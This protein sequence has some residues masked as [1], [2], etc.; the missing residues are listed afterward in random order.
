MAT[1]LNRMQLHKYTNS[2]L[3]AMMAILG[4]A[5]TRIEEY[6]HLYDDATVRWVDAELY[7]LLEACFDMLGRQQAFTD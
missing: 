5:H 4:E 1:N 6:K 7:S 2:E 3:K